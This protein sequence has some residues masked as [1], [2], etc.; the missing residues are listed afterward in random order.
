MRSGKGDK[1]E[2]EKKEERHN[3][4]VNPFS[5]LFSGIK[6][7]FAGSAKK[8]D[9]KNGG[10]RNDEKDE[11]IDSDNYAEK[12]YRSQAIIDARKKCY[13]VYDSFKKS[14]KMPTLPGYG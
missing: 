5:S 2:N 9:D 12:V 7:L 11:K 4:D 10:E 13:R 3:E 8:K 1:E 14:R 6:D